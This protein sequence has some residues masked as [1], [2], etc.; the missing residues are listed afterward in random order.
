M[1]YQTHEQIIVI[2][3]LC[4]STGKEIPR[5]NDVIIAETIIDA[6]DAY[7]ANRAVK[8]IRG[9]INDVCKKKGS[10]ITS[11]IIFHISGQVKMVLKQVDTIIALHGCQLLTITF[12]CQINMLLENP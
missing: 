7:N 5:V 12:F 1:F 4:I 10:N 11:A 6:P 9:L 3:W 2:E 8:M